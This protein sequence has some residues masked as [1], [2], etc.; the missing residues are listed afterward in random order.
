[1]FL[2]LLYVDCLLGNGHSLK[3]KRNH[4]LRLSQRIRNKFNVAISEVE[5]QNLWQRSSLLVVSLNSSKESLRKNLSAILETM[6]KEPY[7]Q[8]LSYEIKDFGLH[9]FLR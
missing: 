5:G 1:M 6:E 3:E 8:L 7:F 9:H 2:G 4:L